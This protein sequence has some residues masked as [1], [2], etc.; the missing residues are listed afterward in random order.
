MGPSPILAGPASFF[1]GDGSLFLRPEPLPPEADVEIRCALPE[2]VALSTAWPMEERRVPGGGV[3]RVGRPDATFFDRESHLAFGPTLAVRRFVRAGAEVERARLPGAL[4]VT[5]DALD[6]WLGGAL[7]A[8]ATVTGRFPRARV[9]IVVVP[10]PASDAPVPFGLLRRGGGSS[11]MLLVSEGADLAA[12]E[13]SWV[14]AHELSHLLFPLIDRR[15][16]WLSEGLATYYQEIVRARAG[17]IEP[18]EAFEHLER[19]FER[20]RSAVGDAPLAIASAQMRARHDYVRVYWSGAAFAL[21]ADVELRRRGTS[22]DALIAAR[23]RELWSPRGRWSARA[24]L[25]ALERPLE[26]P[27]LTTLAARFEADVD[28]PD[29]DEAYEALGLATN[30]DGSLSFSDAPS[31]RALRG[32]I[33]GPPSRR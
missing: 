22:L 18:A 14:A 8:V 6:R 19:G 16:A 5:D 11:V 7:D 29:L 15:D 1:G 23:G 12:L 27:F 21:M 31:A 4:A 3:E 10:V 2:G 32:A 9:Q 25:G 30:A 13:Q 28:F 17:L 26:G 24:L 33:A 20:G